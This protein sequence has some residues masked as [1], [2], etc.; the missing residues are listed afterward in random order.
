MKLEKKKEIVRELKEKFARSKVV[1]VTD[2]KGLD[3]TTIN[4][5]R[6]KLGEV[7]VEYKVVKN[8][9]LI[10]ASEKTDSELIRD[11]FKGPS[12][13]A[14]SYDDPVAPA[15]V[16]T[17]FAEENK[18]LEIKVGVLNGK[19]LDPNAIKALSRLPGREILL[20]QLLGALSGVP[21]AFVRILGA[22]PV[23]L[24]NVLQAIKDQKEAA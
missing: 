19:V 14:V 12:A 23:Q 15:K 24:L 20:G 22:L 4:D 13:I 21:T 3:V 8:S 18:N 17:K 2:Y 10:R 7:D 5:L 6:R 11:S 1:I 16:L 9:L